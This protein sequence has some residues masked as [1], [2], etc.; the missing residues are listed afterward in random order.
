MTTGNTTK[1]ILKHTMLFSFFV[2]F[3]QAL[4]LVRDLYLAKVFGVGQVLD[5]Y[6]LAFKIPDFLNVFYSVF[7]GSVVFIPLLTKLKNTNY[8]NASQTSGDDIQKIQK[9]EE[10]MQGKI[11]SVGSL[12]MFSLVLVF[13]ILE[14]FM[15]QLTKLLAPTWTEEGRVLLTSLS[16]ILLVAQFFFPVGILGG[17]V[18][19]VYGKPFGMA[20]SGFIYNFGI[21][22]GAIVLVPFLGIYGLAV[23]VILGAILF[24]LVQV[25]NAEPLRF[26]KNFRIVA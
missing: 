14:I 3:A 6:Y 5:T 7:L 11:N 15:P 9:G 19:M 20:V 23:S 10:L 18:G 8:T 4:G 13:L 21:L 1:I 16:R 12:V 2:L 25:W 24:M 26:L 17:S 22:L